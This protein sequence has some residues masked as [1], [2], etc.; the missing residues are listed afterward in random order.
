MVYSCGD[1]NV[2]KVLGQIYKTGEGV[3][4]DIQRVK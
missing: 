2:Q 1:A 3:A 4:I